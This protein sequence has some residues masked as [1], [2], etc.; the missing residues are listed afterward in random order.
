MIT[1][2]V[3]FIDSND[4]PHLDESSYYVNIYIFYFLLEYVSDT[5]ILYIPSGS[6]G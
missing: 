3:Y 4:I 5:A 1:C 6:Y 2:K